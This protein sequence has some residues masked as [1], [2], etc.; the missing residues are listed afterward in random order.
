MSRDEELESS[1]A[2]ESGRAMPASALAKEA[3]A[4]AKKAQAKGKGA[5]GRG[6]PA[7][8]KEAPPEESRESP[9]AEKPATSD[10]QEPPTTSRAVPAPTEV[11]ADERPPRRADSAHSV[12]AAKWGASRDTLALGPQLLLLGKLLIGILL[13]M[14]VLWIIC[15]TALTVGFASTFDAGLGRIVL[16]GFLVTYVVMILT[17]VAMGA[18]LPPSLVP[19]K[20][21]DAEGLDRYLR[22]VGERLE[23][24]PRVQFESRHDPKRLRSDVES[25]F[26]HLDRAADELIRA[27]SSRVLVS[28]AVSRNGK[29]DGLAVLLMQARLIWRIAG[30]YSQG[31]TVKE[32][33][34]LYIHVTRVNFFDDDVKDPN[35]DDDLG[36]VMS[37]FA[38]SGVEL[39]PAAGIRAAYSTLVGSVLG[40]SAN[41]FLT[42][43]VGL[44][45]KRYCGS[46]T[47]E[48][49]ASCRRAATI[50]A[51]KLLPD[52]VSGDIE[53]I[54]AA[55]VSK[56]RRLD[57][58]LVGDRPDAATH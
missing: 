45:A 8:G 56:F 21:G 11:R 23:A 51:A 41:A 33:A 2:R 6:A 29:L 12:V 48:E 36:P 37:S 57:A 47:S 54:R 52:V 58:G 26:R 9:K 32:L 40:G 44:I 5:K 4:R 22:A 1:S 27:T 46:I 18:R 49:P 53:R 7:G 3:L 35:L 28:T 39:M 17:L 15:L 16:Y 42:L 13:A 50:E 43:R 20:P 10:G 30:L 14:L 55:V 24:N 31:A 34:H 38:N 25:A 19:P